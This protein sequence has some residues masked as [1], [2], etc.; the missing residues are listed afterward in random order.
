[1]TH[2]GSKTAYP[3][4][5]T[6]G[7]IP[8]YF[9]QK[10]SY[11][12]QILLA[13][14]PTTK[15]NLITN[16]AA[17]QRTLANL[18]HSCLRQILLPIETI[19]VDGMIIT[20]GDGIWRRCHPVFALFVGDYPEQIFAAGCKY[21]ECPKCQVDKKELGSA[22]VPLL[23]RDLMA[24]L[25]A[26]AMAEIDLSRYA[27]MCRDTGIKPIY[28][29]FWENL[30]YSHIYQSIAP[31]VLHQ[32][33]AGIMKYLVLW[34]AK[35]Y[36]ATELDAHC[37][38]LPPNHNIRGFKNGISSL[39]RLTGKE[40]GQIGRILLGAIADARI[41]NRDHS[42]H[43]LLTAVRAMLDF[44]TIAQYPIHT[45]DSLQQLDGAL[46]AF[47]QNKAIFIDLEIR[48]NFNIPKLHACRHYA[49]AIASYGTTDNYSTEHTE[50]LHKDFIKPA[51]RASNVRDEFFQM[52]TW[53]ER[54]EMIIQQDRLIARRCSPENHS[55]ER[56]QLPVLW[57]GRHITMAKRPS[58]HAVTINSIVNDY[59]ATYIRDALARFIVQLNSPNLTLAQ[60]ERQSLYIYLPFLMLPVYRRIKFRDDNSTIIDAIHVQPKQKDN[61]GRIVPARFDMGLIDISGDE[62]TGNIHSTSSACRSMLMSIFLTTFPTRFSSCSNTSRL[63]AATKNHQATVSPRC[64]CPSTSRIR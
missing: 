44:I 31:D 24:A 45:T 59:G 20:G 19:G 15:L 51:Y 3:V 8:K 22:T 34:C 57:R 41:L 30:P 49:T 62:A 10:A 50:R 6:I 25:D 46:D 13:Y 7:N 16:K 40:H 11:R 52:T 56:L 32:L 54:N 14:L 18:F 39:T 37:Q 47:H 28:R 43:R 42:G 58:D 4:Y 33:L 29:P 2:F 1:M 64:S 36:G 35:A 55:P 48:K 12:A 63:H 38:R 60:V 23:T 61:R 27:A 53:M 5:I 17:R 26:L 9:R 21:G